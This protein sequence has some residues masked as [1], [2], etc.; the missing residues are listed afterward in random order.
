MYTSNHSTLCVL[1]AFSP[2][3]PVCCWCPPTAT[4]QCKN[5]EQR[6]M[7]GQTKAALHRRRPELACQGRRAVTLAKA[8]FPGRGAPTV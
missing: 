6:N 1:Q 5:R 2:H 8:W 7:G 4:A 3:L